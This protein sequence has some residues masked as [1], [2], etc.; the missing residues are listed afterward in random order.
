M[1]RFS[2]ALAEIQKNKNGITLIRWPTRFPH[3]RSLKIK[4]KRF[5]TSKS[6]VSVSVEWGE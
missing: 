1:L 6:S 2:F 5:I 4:E 3:F